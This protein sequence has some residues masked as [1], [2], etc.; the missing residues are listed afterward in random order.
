MTTVETLLHEAVSVG[1]GAFEAALAAGA[2]EIDAAAICR[3]YTCFF[4]LI[5]SSQPDALNH[6]SDPFAY[7]MRLGD[8]AVADP[9]RLPC[10][11]VID[12]RHG[13]LDLQGE[14]P[15]VQRALARAHRY[16]FD[17][18]GRLSA[19]DRAVVEGLEWGG[20]SVMTLVCAL[21]AMA[22][23]DVDVVRDHVVSGSPTWSPSMCTMSAAIP[24]DGFVVGGS[25]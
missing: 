5:L 6:V 19:G 10:S 21:A 8:R 9:S 2:T 23:D 20:L 13:D 22:G 14:S 18:L 1:R 25:C 7:G 17:H 24:P 4:A 12:L 15:P 3:A 11:D 16:V